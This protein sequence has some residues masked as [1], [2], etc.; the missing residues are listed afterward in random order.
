[1]FGLLRRDTGH[2]SPCPAW[3]APLAG[4]SRTAGTRSCSIVCWIP[5]IYVDVDV[6]V[7]G[8]LRARVARCST[9]SCSVSPLAST[10]WADSAVLSVVRLHILTSRTT[11][12][13]YLFVAKYPHKLFL[14]SLLKNGWLAWLQIWGNLKF[15]LVSWPE[16]VDIPDAGGGEE[17]GP[18]LGEAHPGRCQE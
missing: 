3:N 15:L 12:I 10:R 1:M 14:C 8:D 5:C 16:V 18:H 11:Y 17:G 6:H 7:S 4:S 13:I 2:T 9:A